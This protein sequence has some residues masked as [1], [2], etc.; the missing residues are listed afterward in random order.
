MGG[1]FVILLS[2]YSII[3]S[4]IYFECRFS[5]QDS[6]S[7]ISNRGDTIFLI[8][9]LILAVAF[10][11][12]VGKSF[13]IIFIFIFV[14]GT[15]FLFSH[16]NFNVYYNNFLM[17]RIV[18]ALHSCLM[19]GGLMLILASITLDHDFNATFFTY[20]VGLPFIILIVLLRV[21]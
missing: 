15:L 16:F 8:F 20:I 12:L 4:L 6:F 3:M 1:L 18:T 9:K 2:F 10:T 5:S 11:F 17:S 7:K 19:W 14:S 13:S 21:E